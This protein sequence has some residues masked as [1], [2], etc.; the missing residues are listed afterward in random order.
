V[1]LQYDE[2]TGG[3]LL[4]WVGPDDRMLAEGELGRTDD[5][6]YYGPE[7]AFLPGRQGIAWPIAT[8]VIGIV[9]PADG[10]L[11]VQ[12]VRIPGLRGIE[13]VVVVTP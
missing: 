9:R 6:G 10:R 1:L 12:E 2:R 3:P 5:L 13:Q 7:L 8:D 4:R 11:A